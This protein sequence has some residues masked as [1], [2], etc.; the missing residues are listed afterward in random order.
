MS[1][2]GCGGATA[3]CP[4]PLTVLDRHRAEAEDAEQRAIDAEDAVYEAEDA[5]AEAARRVTLSRAGLDS[6]RAAEARAETVAM[7]ATC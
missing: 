2:F 6:L 1:T 3:P 5:V 4:T 7:T